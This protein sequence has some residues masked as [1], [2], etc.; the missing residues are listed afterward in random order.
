VCTPEVPSLH[1]TREKLAF[2]KT[3]ELDT[4]VSVVLNRSP[5]SL[6]LPHSRCR[7][8]WACR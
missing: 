8:F 6:C 3:M 2:L 4:R 1:L 7:T 5:N